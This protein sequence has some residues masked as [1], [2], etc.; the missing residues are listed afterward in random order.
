MDHRP[1]DLERAIAI[2]DKRGVLTETVER[3]RQYGTRA[4]RA[5]DPFPDGPEKAIFADLVGFCIERAF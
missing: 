5:L 4:T 1:G 2:L 3:A